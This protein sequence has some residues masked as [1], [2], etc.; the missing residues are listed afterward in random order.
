LKADQIL[1][2]LK[3]AAE[4]LNITVMEHSF[5][6]TGIPVKSGY[7]IVK[8]QQRFILDKH[9]PINKKNKILAGFL[10]QQPIDELYLVPKVREFLQGYQ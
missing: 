8:G 9:L 3:M 4:K 6:T 7:C 2:Q 10:S 5:R 1:E